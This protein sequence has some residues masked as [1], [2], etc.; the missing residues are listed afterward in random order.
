MRWG[1]NGRWVTGEDSK[2]ESWIMGY[3]RT[4]EVLAGFQ[5]VKN[6]ERAGD[7]Q[8]FGALGWA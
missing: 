7:L 1:I 2:R 3:G 8:G 5:R 6:L 4:V